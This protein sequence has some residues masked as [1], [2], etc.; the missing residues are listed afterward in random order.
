M[1]ALSFDNGT[2]TLDYDVDDGTGLV[3]IDS[4]EEVEKRDFVF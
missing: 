4:D 2:T 3:T 1:T